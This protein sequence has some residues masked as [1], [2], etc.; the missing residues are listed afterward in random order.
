MTR[1]V[2]PAYDVAF[3]RIFGQEDSKDLLLDFL[4]D[5]LEGKLRT[6]VILADRD[7]HEQFSDKLRF[8]FVELPFFSKTKTECVTG[9]D[10]WIYTLKN[11]QTLKDIPFK[12]EKPIFKKLEKI[13]DLTSLSKEERRM[14]DA[15]IRAYRDRLAQINSAKRKAMREG[16]AEGRAEGRAEGEAE[17]RAKGERNK[18]IEMVRNMKAEG[19]PVKVIS[20]VSGLSVEEIEKL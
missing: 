6:D 10:K 4:N 17:G 9:L 15:D 11:M 8:I 18:Q 13:A 16:K 1:F 19:I 2:N 12:E 3:K 14:Y 5:L 7:T 20:K